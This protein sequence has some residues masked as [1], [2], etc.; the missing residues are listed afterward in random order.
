MSGVQGSGR[1]SWR[2]A[3][4]HVLSAVHLEEG[5]LKLSAA[6]FIQGNTGF[7]ILGRRMASQCHERGMWCV[8][9]GTRAVR[10]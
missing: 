3:V 9:S 7:L 5:A 6:A 8:L 10:P 4:H 2:R 1:H